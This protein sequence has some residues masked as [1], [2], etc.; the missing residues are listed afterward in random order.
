MN[1][2]R[3]WQP[4]ERCPQRSP[5]CRWLCAG[6]QHAH[7]TH[8]CRRTH[9]LAIPPPDM[10]DLRPSWGDWREMRDDDG[11]DPWADAA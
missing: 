9:Q 2:P 3:C 8:F 7:G 10:S 6:W 4:I 1:C 11:L 5:L